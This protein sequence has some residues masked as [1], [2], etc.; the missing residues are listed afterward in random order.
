M[1][2]FFR[3]RRMVDQ[4]LGKEPII[5]Y[6]GMI[7][8]PAYC[9]HLNVSL[10]VGAAFK[11][12]AGVI[13]GLKH[14]GLNAQLLSLPVLD[15]LLS[16]FRTKHCVLD[17]DG[18]L[19]IFL[20]TFK[21]RF[22][23]RIVGP[24]VFARFALTTITRHDV[25][26]VYNHA[27]EYFLLLIILRFKGIAAYQDIEDVP[28]SSERS[29]EGLINSLFFKLTFLLTS[30]RK[31]VV[32]R[33]VAVSL[34]LADYLVINGAFSPVSCIV[35]D[36]IAKWNHF[37]DGGSLCIHYGGTLYPATGLELFIQ[38]LQILDSQYAGSRTIRFFVTGIGDI[39]RLSH[40]T[41][42][43]VNSSIK[44]DI[45]P[46]IPLSEYESILSQCHLSLSLRSPEA[47]ISSTTFPSKVI[48]ASSRGLALLT[49]DVSDVSEV[50]DQHS[51]FYLRNF[52]PYELSKLIAFAA[53]NP[54]M[55]YEKSIAGFN[56]TNKHFSPKVI[57]DSL[58]SFLF[59][60]V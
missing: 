51:A 32:S 47:A 11:K 50:Y 1:L 5:Y 31:V 4:G 28:I 52:D 6:V 54:N 38:A 44:L 13:N 46:K 40:F 53:N 30:N 23:R 60:S 55:V 56:K 17:D 42:C 18:F 8:S 35:S 16:P 34:Q 12:M 26:I 20:P 24:L 41:H 36:E 2:S 27:P 10:Y 57:G 22:F 48:E 9:N 19:E 39:H 43:L 33:Q 45:H 59:R 49:S 25:V 21:N 29:L 37:L 3:Q 7:N 15:H 58:Q 14:S